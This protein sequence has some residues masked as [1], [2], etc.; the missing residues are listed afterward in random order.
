MAKAWKKERDKSKAANAARAEAGLP[1]QPLVRPMVQPEEDAEFHALPAPRRAWIKARWDHMEEMDKADGREA[2]AKQIAEGYAGTQAGPKGHGFSRTTLLKLYKKWREAG[3]DWR[4]LDRY[5]ALFGRE[6]QKPEAFNLT[7]ESARAFLA[8][9]GETLEAWCA[10][11]KWPA[12]TASQVL[13]GHRKGPQAQTILATL[14]REMREE[15]ASLHRELRQLREAHAEHG[16][17]LD[18]LAARLPPV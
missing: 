16:R 14:A 8:R 9:R 15:P 12:S 18:A 2:K 7:P 4:A 10:R 11:Y 3:R 13:N 6:S 5:R 1:V 17:R